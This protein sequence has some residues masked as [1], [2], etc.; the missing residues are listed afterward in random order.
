MCFSQRRPLDDGGMVAQSGY[1]FGDL[2]PRLLHVGLTARAVPID[3]LLWAEL[4]K[5]QLCDYQ[6]SQAVAEVIELGLLDHGE[7][8]QQVEVAVA[9]ETQVAVVTLRCRRGAVEIFDGKP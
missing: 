9:V 3:D 6:D 5:R 4:E 7:I 2:K 1:D 8:D